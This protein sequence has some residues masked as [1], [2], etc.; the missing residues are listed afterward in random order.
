MLVRWGMEG[1]GHK[2]RGRGMEKVRGLLSVRMYV[3]AVIYF[4]NSKVT[5]FRNLVAVI[6]PH[7]LAFPSPKIAPVS[8][9]VLKQT[10]MVVACDPVCP[11]LPNKKRRSIFRAAHF[12]QTYNSPLLLLY[13]HVGQETALVPEN[14]LQVHRQ[15]HQILRGHL[16]L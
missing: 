5:A 10:I 8:V 2:G 1:K 12:I 11:S 7:C 14:V 15:R 3:Y 13:L 4:L 6:V 16:C 9:C